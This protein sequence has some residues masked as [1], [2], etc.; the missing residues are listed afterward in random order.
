MDPAGVARAGAADIAQ[1]AAVDEAVVLLG[2]AAGRHDDAAAA[3]SRPARA[4]EDLSFM[5]A[6]PRRPLRKIGRR[7]SIRHHAAGALSQPNEAANGSVPEVAGVHGSGTL[8]DALEE[9]RGEAGI[10]SFRDA[11]RG[12]RSGPASAAA[13]L[14]LLAVSESGPGTAADLEAG[15]AV[16]VGGA[17]SKIT[18]CFR[19]HGLAGVGDSA[20]AFP[21]LTGQAAFYM[22]KQL[23]DYAS[24][25]RPNDVMTPIAREMTEPQMAHVALYYSV[26]D[27]P[28]LERPPVTEEVLARGREIA[29]DGLEDSDVDACN[30]CHGR[31]GTGDPPLFPY[32]AG[33][34]APYLELQLLL[35]KDDIRDN[36]GL[37]VMSTIA[38]KLSEADI[39]AVS[40]YYA[41]LRPEALGLDTDREQVGA[42][43]DAGRD[44]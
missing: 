26:M 8:L 1:E 29:E 6:I 44:G 16:V 20:G 27:A 31:N 43:G 30:L 5:G 13:L 4:G 40:L 25:A 7:G 37:D 15:R 42:V 38:A 23:I 35:F 22:Y 2:G 11:V 32:L 39:R 21:R 19:C 9:G 10:L 41:W 28:Y 17:E 36:D 14:V 24:G 18:P 34:Y 33:Q 12:W 3:V